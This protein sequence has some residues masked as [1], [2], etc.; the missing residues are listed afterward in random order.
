MSVTSTPEAFVPGTVPGQAPD[1]FSLPRHVDLASLFLLRSPAELRTKPM[2][3][4]L[5]A[6]ISEVFQGLEDMAQGL[7]QAINIE[8]ESHRQLDLVGEGVG[9]KRDGRSDADYRIAARVQWMALY[10]TRS[11]DLLYDIMGL[12]IGDGPQTFSYRELAPAHYEVTVYDITAPNAAAWHP[13]VR[14]AKPEG[15]GMSFV[16]VENTERVFQF[17][18]GPGFDEGFLAYHL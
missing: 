8:G 6:V 14:Q 4:G 1:P 9:L 13:L 12:L 5:V 3:S 18:E 7:R 11:I 15:V 17:D 16:V 10:R 2:W